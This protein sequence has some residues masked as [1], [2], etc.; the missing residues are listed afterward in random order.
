MEISDLLRQPES[1]TLEF[2]SD[3]SSLD[4]ILKTIVAFANT[5]GGILVI[6]CSSEGKLLGVSDIFKAEEKLANA[7]ADSIFPSMQPEIEICTVQNENILIL[8]VAYWKGPFYL[9]KLGTPQGV[10]VRLGS[11]SRPAGPE[12]V[13]D[14]QRNF[15]RLSFD[16]EALPETSLD[17]LCLE[18]IE[19]AF[20]LVGK[21]VDQAKLLS[22]GVL[23]KF[24]NKVV[25]SVGGIILFGKS[26]VRQRLFPDARVSCARFRG[27]DKAE[28][29]DRFE[30]EGTILD[31]IDDVPK[32]IARNTRLSSEIQS[33]YRKD[34]TEYP[35]IALREVL[36]NALAHCDYSVI[37]SGIQIAI[38]NDRL[39]IQNPGM[40]PFG[41]TMEDFK[42]G[43]SRVRNRVI[44]RVFNQ[45]KLME[46]WGSGY[47]RIVQACQEGGYPEPEWKELGTAVRVIFRPH[48]I[49]VISP[50]GRVSGESE[51]LPSSKDRAIL[52]AFSPGENLS[53]SEIAAKLSNTIPERSLRASLVR[54]R[55]R[56]FLMSR[57]R[58]RAS[59][60][61]RPQ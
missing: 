43:A 32:F 38:F 6:G 35:G 46:V 1:K 40:L 42:A 19:Q 17:N 5:A 22:L 44:A 54:L 30:V 27:N 45:L 25:C 53:I 9:R 3:L 4:P 59:T 2:K 23:T 13:A 18:R 50:T 36:I 20:L 11:T 61:L 14:M 31:A 58:G 10:Y 47:R 16:E 15:L 33:M 56:G 8:R 39:E 21:E 26:E 60:W 41:F 37:G 24:A 55:E 49:S 28:F 7:I 51:I 57:G 52:E 12:L 34:V 48:A 29:I